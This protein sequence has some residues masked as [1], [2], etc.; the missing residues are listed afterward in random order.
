M[1]RKLDLG[2]TAMGRTLAD[3]V[4]PPRAGRRFTIP[5][6]HEIVSAG[7]VPGRDRSVAVI[8]VL[9]CGETLDFYI[10]RKRRPIR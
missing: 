3:L 1:A 10:E 5:P 4:Q 8:Q 7:A 9:W 6:W 2:Q